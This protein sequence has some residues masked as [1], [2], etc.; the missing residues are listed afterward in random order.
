MTEQLEHALYLL[1]AAFTLWMLIDAFRRSEGYWPWVILFLPGLGAWAYF[2]AVLVPRWTGGRGWSLPTFRRRPSLDE[3]HFRAEQSPT[4]ANH[5]DLA[6][7]LVERHEP[8]EA[9]PHLTEVLAR[10]PD[11]CRAL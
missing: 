8:A 6:E 11:H 3:L 4:L 7:R 5:L 9:V 2:F 10:E 1:Q